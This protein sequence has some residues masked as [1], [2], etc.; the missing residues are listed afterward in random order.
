MIPKVTFSP[1]KNPDNMIDT[2]NYFLI[3]SWKWFDW[4]GTFTRNYPDFWELISKVTKPEEKVKI[5][6]EYFKKLYLEKLDTIQ[7]IA[8]DYQKAWNKN[9]TQ[10]LKELSE[11]LEIEWPLDSKEIKSWIWLN[12][13]CPRY[14]EQREFD[15]FWKQTPENM[16]VTTLH[17][18]L[19]FIWFEK[20]KEVFP[21]YDKRHFNSPHLVWKLSEMVPLAILSDKRIQDLFKHE[22]SVYNEWKLKL[23]NWKPLLEYLQD[24]YNNRKSFED[25]MVK[26][27]EFVKEN[28][29]EVN[30]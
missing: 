13:I 23:I 12:P 7:D 3:H 29:E 22:P 20:W 28:E 1:N 14:I 6:V 2:I 9:G 26:S 8:Q 11:I 27:W 4:S 30:K 5:S 21:D 24:F 15:I 18:S 25:F 19:H 10:L 16:K 17:E